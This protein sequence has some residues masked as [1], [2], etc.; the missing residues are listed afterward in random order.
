[1]TP[2]LAVGLGLLTAVTL[3][4]LGEQVLRWVLESTYDRTEDHHQQQQQRQQQHDQDRQQ[5][6]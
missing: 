2:M 6:L 3:G 1:M 4:L 5:R